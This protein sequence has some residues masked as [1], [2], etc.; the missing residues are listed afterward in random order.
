M[1]WYIKKGIK[2]DLN[3]FF[4]RVQDSDDWKEGTISEKD[5]RELISQK[6]ETVNME[7]VKR[8]IIRFIKNPKQLDIR[9][10]TYFHDLVSHLQIE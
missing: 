6:I 10:S 4:T 5:F 9:S 1:E 7:F 8:D 2:L 3:H